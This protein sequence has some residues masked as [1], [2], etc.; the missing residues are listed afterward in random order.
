M[1]LLSGNHKDKKKGGKAAKSNKPAQ[2][3]APKPGKGAS[4]FSKKPVRTG[5]TRGS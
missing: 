5:G 1:S 3:Q 4:G 2:Q